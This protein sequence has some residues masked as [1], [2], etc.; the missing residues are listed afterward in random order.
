MPPCATTAAAAPLLLRAAGRRGPSVFAAASASAAC[1]GPGPSPELQQ[2]SQ[3]TTSRQA[4]AQRPRARAS[5]GHLSAEALATHRAPAGPLIAAPGALRPFRAAAHPLFCRC[6]RCSAAAAAIFPAAHAR[7]ALTIRV[8]APCS[9]AS[10]PTPPP[11]GVLGAAG[12]AARAAG[13]YAP[14][15]GGQGPG[16]GLRAEPCRAFGPPLQRP[17]RLAP[18]PLGGGPT[19][20]RDE[21]QADP[22]D[23]MVR[24]VLRSAAATADPAAAPAGPLARPPPRAPPRPPPWSWFCSATD[25]DSCDVSEAEASA[26]AAAASTERSSRLRGMPAPQ[27]AAAAAAALPALPPARVAELAAAAAALEGGFSVAFG[28]ALVEVVVG[29]MYQFS[30]QQLSDVAAA[31][32]AAGFHDLPFLEALAGRLRETPSQWDAPT[33]AGVMAAFA[34]FDFVGARPGGGGGG[35]AVEAMIEA[36]LSRMDCP[37]AAEIVFAAGEGLGGSHSSALGAA[38][39]TQPV[40]AATA[41]AAW[42]GGRLCEVLAAF[43][44]EPRHMR[45]FGPE[46]LGKLAGGLAGLDPPP[47]PHTD[48]AAAA[49]ARRA[50]EMATI[51]GP[52][53][54][55]HIARF[56]G[57]CG[58]RGTPLDALHLEALAG[59]A[60]DLAAPPTP[61]LGPERAA[62]VAAEL[63]PLLVGAG[64][65]CGLAGCGRANN[66]GLGIA[67]AHAAASC[68]AV[69]YAPGPEW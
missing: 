27:L 44:K 39:G 7:R 1:A 38:S 17:D 55:C 8:A 37:G 58:R 68:G 41:A 5:Q 40:A 64:S 16:P 54:L 13:T 21:V 30:P 23:T 67:A 10:G 11:I 62:A 25:S 26:A 19:S 3:S 20:V 56:L 63:G 43:A 31:L 28:E 12:A 22:R 32:A 69:G 50:A 65:V 53:D 52:D 51:L 2:R 42:R 47:G 59:R 60:A 48:A 36:L 34:R 35:E 61:R 49:V 6:G 46:P 18:G 15:P 14:L 45:V 29:R 57:V 24:L 66:R 33:L 4:Q 9:P